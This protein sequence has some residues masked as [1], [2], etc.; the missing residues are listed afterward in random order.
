MVHEITRRCAQPPTRRRP[1][2]RKLS[3]MTCVRF[4]PIPQLRYEYVVGRKDIRW[5]LRPVQ[6]IVHLGGPLRNSVL[7][8]NL[9][10]DL[11]VGRLELDLDGLIGSAISVVDPVS[12]CGA[13]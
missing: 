11:V 3:L 2:G 10:L 7:A 8:V 9:H 13:P 4:V 1:L 6:L 12:L 5:H